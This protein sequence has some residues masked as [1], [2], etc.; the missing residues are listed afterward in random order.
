MSILIMSEMFRV[1]FGSANRKMVAVRLA[2]FADDEGRGIWPSVDT[3]AS[4]CEIS[5]RTVQRILSEFV[6]EG[7]LVLRERGGGRRTSRYDFDLK[8]VRGMRHAEAE[9]VPAEA[10][11]MAG[12]GEG[13]HGD[14]GDTGDMRGDTVTPLGCHGDGGTVMEP[15]VEP[16]KEREARERDDAGAVKADAATVPGTADFE[17]RVMRLCNG[18]GFTAGAWLDWDTS[19]PG[20]IGRQFARLDEADRQAA[21]RWRDPYLRDMALRK[22]RPVRVGIYLRD[23]L[24]EGLDP[25]LLVRA[26]KA[27]EQGAKVSEV[28]KPD[29][30]GNAYGPVWAAALF[31]VLLGG[32]ERPEL[33]PPAGSVWLASHISRAWPRLAGLKAMAD[34]R[35]G[36]VFP[37][38][39]HRLSARMVFVPRDSAAWSDWAEAMKARGWPDILP[40]RMEGGYFPAGGPGSL[41]GYRAALDGWQD[42]ENGE[43]RRASGAER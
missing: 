33:A 42:G 35:G 27:A 40:A 43:E 17:K 41:E 29:G 11:E 22:K 37:E 13:C 9:N 38:R 26:E 19:S 25:M 8:R 3:I 4:Q 36:G 12:D 2:D 7:I 15:S 32:P 21:E 31:E 6:D 28:A 34:Q 14:T 18:K 30:W 24:W 16:S 20:W 23:R 5:P 10:A 39:L 1:P